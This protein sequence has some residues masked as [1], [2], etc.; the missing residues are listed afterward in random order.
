VHS[1][2]PA[3]EEVCILIADDNAVN[4]KVALHQLRRLGYRAHT[5]E[6]G[7][8]A[9]AAAARGAYHLILM[10]CQMPEV[11][12]FEATRAIRK[13]ELLTGAHVPVIAMTA[14]VFE[15]ERNVCLASGMDDY[16][17]KPVQLPELRA[18]LERFL[19]AVKD[20]VGSAS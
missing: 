19:P 7:A 12:G 5:A 11:D 8:E 13:A 14:N 9:V 3:H 18:M 20:G 16:L 6:N 4:R 10:D 1:E 17:S 15:G 2:E